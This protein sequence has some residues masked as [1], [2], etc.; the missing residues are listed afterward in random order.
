MNYNWENIK[1]IFES[2]G[3]LRDIYIQN[4]SIED[5]EKLI[6]FLNSD[7]NVTYFLENKINKEEVFTY[8]EDETGNAESSTI[9]IELEN[10]K[11]NCHYFFVEQIEFDIAPSQIKTKSDFEKLLLFMTKI[12]LTLGKQVTLT[13]E[14]EANYPLIKIN[15][16]ENIFKI[17]TETEIT[18]YYKLNNSKIRNLFSS[19]KFRFLMFFFPKLIEKKMLKSAN[20]TAKATKLEDNLW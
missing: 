14:N 9:S 12:S 5:W 15:V 6:D 13:G 11:I 7:Y 3:S 18:E 8:F 10:I 2:D 20:E 1:W 16:K 17:I 19:F 4:T